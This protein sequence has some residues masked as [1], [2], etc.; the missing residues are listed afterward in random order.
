MIFSVHEERDRKAK[1]EQGYKEDLVAPRSGS[2]TGIQGLTP[3]KGT[4]SAHGTQ[5]LMHSSRREAR[6]WGE[7]PRLEAHVQGC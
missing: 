1:C 2:S 6:G 3:V 4:K 5:E 7:V